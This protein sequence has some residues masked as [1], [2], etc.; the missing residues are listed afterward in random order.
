VRVVERESEKERALSTTSI[1]RREYIER[2]MMA[3]WAKL[4]AVT[5]AAIQAKNDT[6][7]KQHNEIIAKGNDAIE[8]I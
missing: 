1:E 7:K 6:I 4:Q 3:E 5:N 2:T 8:K